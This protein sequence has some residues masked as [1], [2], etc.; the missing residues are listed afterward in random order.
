MLGRAGRWAGLGAGQGWALGGGWA[1]PGGLAA[2]CWRASP[3]QPLS[4]D[5]GAA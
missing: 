1:G 5:R 3:G 4:I 2:A